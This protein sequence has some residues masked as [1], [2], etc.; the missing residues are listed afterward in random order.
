MAVRELLKCLSVLVSIEVVFLN[1][2][3]HAWADL[4]AASV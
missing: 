1:I 2:Q 3:D 4:F